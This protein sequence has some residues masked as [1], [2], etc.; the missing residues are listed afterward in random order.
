MVVVQQYFTKRRALAHSI[1]T[2]GFSVGYF[3]LPSL[4]RIIIS[5]Y[6][7]SQAL[8]MVSG[9]I[10]QSQ[11]FA[12]L[13]RPLPKMQRDDDGYLNTSDTKSSNIKQIQHTSSDSNLWGRV[14]LILFLIS[15]FGIHIG[16]LVNIIYLPLRCDMINLSKPEAS[17]LLTIIG[18]TGMFFRPALGHL[19]DQLWM[20]R[21]VM[22]GAASVLT[23]VLTGVTSLVYSFPGLIVTAVLFSF[24]S[25]ELRFLNK[26]TVK[27]N[28]FLLTSQIKGPWGP[29]G[30]HLGPTG[31]R[32]APCWPHEPCYQFNYDPNMDT[33]LHLL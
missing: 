8:I 20:N 19:G 11:I 15:V 5:E 28:A 16:Q 7:W 10:L 22:F 25:G 30:T 9:I 12:L 6:G 26:F 18:V 24:F 23:G 13:M 1:Y 17:N 3:T 2:S 4:V 33:W 27:P 29:H 21:V 31:P 14:P 32:W